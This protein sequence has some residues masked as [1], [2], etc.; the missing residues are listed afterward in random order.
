[1][2]RDELFQTDVV[3]PFGTDK[4]KVFATDDSSI[5]NV[6]L[7]FWDKPQGILSSTKIE[8][9]YTALKDSE[10]FKTASIDVNT[11]STDIDTCRRGD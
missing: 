6:A 3:E 11:I 8:Q 7:K 2:K 9:L 10:D 1:M 4:L 5:Y